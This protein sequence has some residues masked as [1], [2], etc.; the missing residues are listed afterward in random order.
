[1][2]TI[3]LV[4]VTTAACYLA[5]GCN[6]QFAREQSPRLGEVSPTPA[7]VGDE[8]ELTIR[9]DR[10]FLDV[11]ISYQDASRS[12][13]NTTFTVHLGSRLLSEVAYVDEHT[14][15]ALVPPDL[16]PGSYDLHVQSPSG[17]K[18]S[19]ANALL[20][21]ESLGGPQT[22]DT[23]ARDEDT[24]SASD[25]DTHI[26]I[27]T[28]SETDTVTADALGAHEISCNNPYGC[29]NVCDAGNCNAQC[30]ESSICDIGCAGG[31][32]QLDCHQNAF[33]D[34]HCDGGGCTAQKTGAGHLVVTCAEGDCSLSCSD[35]STCL[36]FCSGG[37]CNIDCQDDSRCWLLC[38]ADDCAIDN[39][40]TP[41]L[42][43]EESL[44]CNGT[45]PN[46]N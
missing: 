2:R 19:L 23:A 24:E 9:G 25:L 17:Q 12:R 26:G 33:C 34:F 30:A 41:V 22:Q 20:I 32:C 10:F 5:G 35:N 1:M 3:C 15:T 7:V 44:I 36:L 16:E 43:C 37:G 46:T 42:D 31:S 14:L 28:D 6:D 21:V 40:T 11:R 38:A 18:S 29:Y 13:I 4:A 8:T 27:D 45:C 39:C